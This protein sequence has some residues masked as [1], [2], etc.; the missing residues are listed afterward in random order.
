MADEIIYASKVPLLCQGYAYEPVSMYGSVSLPTGAS[1]QV[2][3]FDSATFKNDS[4]WVVHLTHIKWCIRERRTSADGVSTDER[5]ENRVEA[6]MRWHD[7]F[8]QSTDFMPISLWHTP[9]PNMGLPPPIEN[10]VVS[11]RFLRPLLMPQDSVIQ[12][13][14]SLERAETEGTRP[15]S[16]ALHGKGA[17][18]GE[19]RI[20]R[21]AMDIGFGSSGDGLDANEQLTPFEDLTVESDEPILFTDLVMS[22]GANSESEDPTPDYR[23]ARVNIK[24]V[25]AGTEAFWGVTP[26][27]GTSALPPSAD[28]GMPLDL[29]GVTGSRGVTHRIPGGGWILEPGRGFAMDMRN[30]NV[31]GNNALDVCAAA[32]GWR[33]LK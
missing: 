3:S 26:G 6:R 27:V 33:V 28:L 19:N 24:M 1:P 23:L 13:L 20:I 7:I 32:I 22:L 8:Y 15:F 4:P 18:S 25:G 21:G 17:E 16:L 10:G 2:V 9:Q 30:R 12:A 14:V 31:S 11:H 29:W 5:Q